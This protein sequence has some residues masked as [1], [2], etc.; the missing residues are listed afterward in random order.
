MRDYKSVTPPKV[1]PNKVR[2]VRKPRDLQRLVKARG[3]ANKARPERQP[4][5]WKVLLQK[6]LR[7]A[8][9]LVS[10]ALIVGGGVI[11][12]HMLVASDYFR[13]EAVRVENAARVTVEEVVGLSDIQIGSSIFDLN[14][15]MI[16]RRIEE[17]PWIATARIDRVFPREVVIRLEE[18][19]PRAIVNLG[20]LYYVDADGEVF[21]MLSAGDRLDFPVI[22]GIEREDLLDKPEHTR[23]RLRQ[24]L[25]LIDEL[26]QRRR[27]NL[28]SIS[29][30]SLNREEG[31]S[32]YTYLDAVPVQ[33]GE[34]DFA[35]KLDRLEQIYKELEPRLPALRYID[36]KV[37]DRVIVKVDNRQQKARG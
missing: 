14:L 29:E 1:K 16:G 2:R 10:T 20:Y 23:E 27:F 17:N 32:L 4:R 34:G 26:A 13:I 3:K 5:D 33:L 28:E 8:V 7:C 35:Q 9:A 21:K 15:D 31:I 11:A 25:A 37:P 18:R 24:A 36:L 6:T 22:T 30:L 12:A 19:Q